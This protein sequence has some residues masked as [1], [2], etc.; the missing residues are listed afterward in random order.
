M[1]T[2][3]KQNDFFLVRDSVRKW[4]FPLKGRMTVRG[5]ISF[6]AIR[7]STPVNL[8]NIMLIAMMMVKI[9]HDDD[10][11]NHDHV[12]HNYDDQDHDYVDHNDDDQDHNPV[13]HN[14]DNQ[15]HNPVDDQNHDYVDHNDDDQNHHYVDNDSR[16]EVHLAINKIQA[17]FNTDITVPILRRNASNL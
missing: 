3:D 13:D 14:D 15:N 4:T 10:D 7:P 16:D 12:D 1:F 8:Y 17:D 9:D 2:N 11:Q 6:I 5:G